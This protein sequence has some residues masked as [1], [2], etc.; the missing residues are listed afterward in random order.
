M[1]DNYQAAEVDFC[2]FIIGFG[3]K[4]SLATYVNDNPQLHCTAW[5]YDGYWTAWPYYRDSYG[6][7]DYVPSHFIIDRD[8]Y[9]R[10]GKTGTSGVPEI[11]TD[12]ID[13]L[14]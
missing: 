9:I 13:E 8:G 4:S 1:Y 12:C 2:S 3:S 11:L 7:G 5:L 10:L 6:L 14:L